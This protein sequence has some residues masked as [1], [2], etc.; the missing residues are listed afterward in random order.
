[1]AVEHEKRWAD[2]LFSQGNLLGLNADLLK[3][4]VEW[5]ANNRL[6]SLGYKKM[7]ETKKNPLGTWYDQ[8]LNSD[9]VQVAPQETEI[10]SYKIGARDTQVDMSQFEEIDL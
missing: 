10:S 4:Y 9:K 3:K 1:M 6:A 8:Y 2:Y 5:I 7:F